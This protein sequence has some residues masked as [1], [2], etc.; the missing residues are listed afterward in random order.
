MTNGKKIL[1]VVILITCI[2]IQ[3]TRPQFF[4]FC[5]TGIDDWFWKQT[6]F[7]PQELLPKGNWVRGVLLL[8]LL[9]AITILYSIFCKRKH[10]R[11]PTPDIIERHIMDAM[12]SSFVRWALLIVLAVGMFLVVALIL[13][14]TQFTGTTLITLFGV[15]GGVATLIALGQIAW[16]RRHLELGVK[17]P[18]QF[19]NELG[20]VLDTVTPKMSK[21]ESNRSIDDAHFHYL[22]MVHDPLMVNAFSSGDN[23]EHIARK[24]IL[25]R[26]REILYDPEC[27]KKIAILSPMPESAVAANAIRYEAN[28]E[29]DQNLL[30]ALEVHVASKVLHV[31]QSKTDIK[32]AANKAAGPDTG[33]NDATLFEGFVNWKPEKHKSSNGDQAQ[34]NFTDFIGHSAACFR[35]LFVDQWEPAGRDDRCLT[36]YGF[37]GKHLSD[38]KEKFPHVNIFLSDTKGLIAFFDDPSDS[39]DY[40]IQTMPIHSAPMV[41]ALKELFKGLVKDP[42][43]WYEIH[44]KR[45]GAVNTRSAPPSSNATSIATPHSESA[46]VVASDGAPSPPETYQSSSTRSVSEPSQPTEMTDDNNQQSPQ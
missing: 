18:E 45:Q 13:G 2:A 36:F 16:V 31:D 20:D 40:E 39:G 33:R 10:R 6:S 23:R 21:V 8:V 28:Y 24:R 11:Y 38:L 43:K 25:K 14:V 30:L 19:L 46:P 5:F 42:D 41:L 34:R 37:K 29:P 15:L 35:H 9:S 3:I 4:P 44:Q 12:S 32:H 27:Q 22:C 26:M 17:S 7:T 1:Y